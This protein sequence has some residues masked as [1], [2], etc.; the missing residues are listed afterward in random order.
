MRKQFVLSMYLLAAIVSAITIACSPARA[1]TVN[2][3]ALGASNVAGSGVGASYAFPARLEALLR[4][5]GEALLRAKG[6]D[7]SIS[8]AG[9]SGDT[10][11]GMLG[12]LDSAVPNETQIVLLA[13]Y[14]LNDGRRGISDAEHAF[15]TQTI[16]SRLRARGIKIIPV[17]IRGLP[18]QAD[19]IHLTAASHEVVAARLLP[20]V[21]RAI[22]S[23]RRG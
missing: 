18:R 1:A 10:T 21:I 4:A 20:Q 9:I 13:I 7:V 8:N 6:Y 19:E 5:K 22:G 11:A 23:P 3:V 15:N 12:R 14:R 17:N 16:V 2:I